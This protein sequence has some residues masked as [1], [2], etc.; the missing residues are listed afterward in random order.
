MVVQLPTFA[1]NVPAESETTTAAGRMSWDEAFE[2]A[3]ALRELGEDWDGQ[4]A[5]APCS[6]HID[7]CR[8]LLSSI[9]EGDLLPPPTFVAAAPDGA[10]CV[11]WQW[12]G[13]RL[14]AEVADERI[15]W[16]LFREGGNS[17]FFDTSW[18]LQEV[19]G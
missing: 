16:M 4:G 3:D 7:G 17:E 9:Q 10:V 15:E 2:K 5:S 11:E 18:E 19:E 8:I 12:K 14:E 1:F 6:R 13:I